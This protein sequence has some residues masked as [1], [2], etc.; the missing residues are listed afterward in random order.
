MHLPRAVLALP[1]CR[2]RKTTAILWL[3]RDRTPI[4]GPARPRHGSIRREWQ[5]VR[6]T[7]QLFKPGTLALA[8][9]FA[10]AIH[11]ISEIPTPHPTPAERWTCT[12]GSATPTAE[13]F[14]TA[15]MRA[16]SPGVFTWAWTRPG[17]THQPVA[18]LGVGQS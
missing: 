16:T 10:A 6:V 18:A 9:F 3:Q 8:S 13:V 7:V 14:Q 12:T 2:L 1:A 4:T 17:T 11:G 15:S 5:T